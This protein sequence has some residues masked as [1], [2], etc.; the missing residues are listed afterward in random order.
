M[1]LHLHNIAQKT[2]V[3]VEHFHSAIRHRIGG[4]AKAM[5]VTGSRLEAIRYKQSFDDYIRQKRYDIRTLVAFS[6]TV[7]DD[8]RLE[9]YRLQK[10]SEGS[11][12]LTEGEAGALG[13]PTKVGT[14]IARE[15]DVSTLHSQ[16]LREPEGA[17][18]R[19]M[20]THAHQA[21][22]RQPCLRAHRLDRRGGRRA[23]SHRGSVGSSP[24]IA[25][26]A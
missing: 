8:V 26:P 18:W 13:G 12:S 23:R 20:A 1:L 10:I 15:E 21:Q 17:G 11:I 16:A 3:M 7:H 2:Q 4:R 9:Y 6:G 19:L 22:A 24:G 25:I 5:V 14:G